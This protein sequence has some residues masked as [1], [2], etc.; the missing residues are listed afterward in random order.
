[1]LVALVP[2]VVAL[3]ATAAPAS[4]ATASLRCATSGRSVVSNGAARVFSWT[5]RRR[6]SGQRTR[7]TAFYACLRANRRV[8]RLRKPR[9]GPLL[10]VPDACGEKAWLPRLSVRYASFV[11]A[12]CDSRSVAISVWDLAARRVSF[13][14]DLDEGADPV[15]CEVSSEGAVAWLDD[16]DDAVMKADGEGVARIGRAG[17]GRIGIRGTTLSWREGGAVRTYRLVGAAPPN[18]GR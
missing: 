5:R 15:D 13:D 14:V 12:G 9:G 16:A 2:V 3:A 7:V 10:N 17:G 4:G 18:L 8:F 6:Y 11:H 1:M